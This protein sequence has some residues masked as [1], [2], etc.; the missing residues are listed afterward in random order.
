MGE[1]QGNLFEP[2][3]NRSIKVESTDER[4]TSNA[5]V[6]LLREADHRLQVIQ[7]ITEV[8]ARSETPRSYSLFTG[9]TDS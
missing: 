4:L 7:T 3:F 6:L 2:D 9:G 8:N 1:A 5:G